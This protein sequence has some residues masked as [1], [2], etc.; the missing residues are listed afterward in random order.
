MAATGLKSKTNREAQVQALYSN[1]DRITKVG[2]EHHE[3]QQDH[4]DG[5]HGSQLSEWQRLVSPGSAGASTTGCAHSNDNFATSYCGA[6][7]SAQAPHLAM[8][9]AGQS[10]RPA[11]RS[12]PTRT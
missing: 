9:V 2:G 11:P 3:G 6:I 12:S 4:R 5:R 1:S 7:V 8:A 10:T